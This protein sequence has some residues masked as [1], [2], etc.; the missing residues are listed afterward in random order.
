MGYSV[1]KGSKA[2]PP[3]SF[4]HCAL[5]HDLSASIPNL[6][7]AL[8][9]RGCDDFV[10]RSHEN[11]A[12]GCFGAAGA[13]EADGGILRRYPSHSL[14][15]LRLVPWSG[16]AEGRAAPGFAGGGPGGRGLLWAGDR[17]WKEHGEPARPFR[18]APGAGYGDASE[19]G[20]ASR[21]NGGGAASLDRPRGEMAGHEG[22]RGGERPT[23]ARESGADLQEGGDSLGFPAGGES[24]SR[25]AGSRPG[26]D[27]RSGNGE[28][29]GEG[30]RVI[31]ARRC[32]DFAEAVALRSGRAATDSGGTGSIYSGVCQRC[33]CGHGGQSG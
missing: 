6:W 31:A 7:C 10:G 12:P 30:A 25:L 4:L 16:Q 8:S 14:A 2:L 18:L 21:A 29:E 13:S 22:D 1:R 32:E 5:S 19:K 27:R 17:S 3:S 9:R 15:V 23:R 11:R 20:S 33:G 26:D 28:A 24:R